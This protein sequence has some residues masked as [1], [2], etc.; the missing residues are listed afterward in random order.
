MGFG[1]MF[2][3]PGRGWGWFSDADLSALL[4]EYTGLSIADVQDAL[5]NDQTLAD[6]ITANDQSVDDFI[7]AGGIVVQRED[8]SFMFSEWPDRVAITCVSRSTPQ[9]DKSPI[10]SNTLCRGSS[11]SHRSVFSLTP[12]GPSTSVFW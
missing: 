7:A 3:G 8:G 4:E 6:L 9:I 10:R 11:S 1:K 2:D 12:F 5:Q